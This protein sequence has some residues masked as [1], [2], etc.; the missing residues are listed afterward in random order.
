[1]APITTSTSLPTAESE[2][3]T[4][5]EWNDLIN[6]ANSH[7]LSNT[8]NY[9]YVAGKFDI[10]TFIDYLILQIHSGNFD[11]PGN[12]WTVHREKSDT[13]KFRFSIWDAEGIA[14]SWIF[15]DNCENCDM[16]A[17][18]DFPTWTSPT[19]LNNLS[20]DPTSQIYRALKANPN[21]R[22]LFADRIH[23]HY[24]NGGILTQSH[25]MDKWWEVQNEVSERPSMAK[26]LMCRTSFCRSE[27]RMYW[28]HLKP[29]VLF[30]RAFG[31]PV[32]NVNGSYKF[33]GYVSSSDTFTITDPCASGG[34]I[35]YTTD[36][37]DPRL[38]A[39][40]GHQP[41]S[42]FVAEN[43]SKKVLVPDKRYRHNLAR[44]PANHIMIPA[45][46]AAR[47]RRL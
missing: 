7:D 43:A 22:Q 38:P 3:A 21:F 11:W 39:H 31:A 24:N 34:T 13:G 45:G 17:F 23:K 8:D 35:Y 33:G 37:S 40:L 30:N 28:P 2:T 16:T 41:A 12:N 29:T 6:Y 47:R 26:L 46:Q 14:E 36:G 4:A 9:N 27:N 5:T 15:G 44:R 20:W 18:E 25:L 32:F 1:M 42:T 19:G 10:V